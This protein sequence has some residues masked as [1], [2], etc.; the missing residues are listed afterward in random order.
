MNLKSL[1]FVSANLL[2]AGNLA[3]Q[4]VVI[5]DDTQPGIIE[6]TINADT[7]ANGDRTDPNTI[8][9]LKAGKIY[10]QNG[11]IIVIIQG[12]YYYPRCGRRTKT[13]M[14]KKEQVDGNAVGENKIN[15][16]LS[17]LNIQYENKENTGVLPNNAF[18]L[19]GNGHTLRVEDCLFEHCALLAFMAGE[20]RNGAKIIYRNNYFR[21]MFNFSQWW[22]GRIGECKHDIDTLIIENNTMTGCGLMWLS[23]KSV[24]NVAIINH[25]TII[26]NHK[27]PF[28]NPY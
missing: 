2:I 27:Y 1:L 17:F 28:L 8:Y 21:D 6:A 7:L 12:Y 14:G 11:P 20:I 10:I 5:L 22:G 19:S 26:N 24:T 3:A 18:I 25:N 4:T 23:Q 15:S 13:S 16:S 9:E